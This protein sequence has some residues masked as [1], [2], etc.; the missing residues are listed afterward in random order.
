[1]KGYKKELTIIFLVIFIDLLG[2]GIII[3]IIPYYLEEFVTQPDQI[4]KVIAS[5]ITVYSLM[6]FIFS[7]I[8]GR[9]SD[10]IGR[11]PIL[12][13]SLAGSAITHVIFALG[14]NL[15]VLFVARI[16]TGIF[17][18]TVP[19]AMAYIS[20][21]TPPEDRA[22]GMGIVGA[23]FGLGFILGPALGGIVSGFAGHRVPL[24][25]AAGF[26]MTA[27]TFAYLKLKET[28]DTK[29]PVV[30]D[31]QR[32]NLKNLYRALHHP[33]LGILFLIFFIVS[34]SF[35]NFETIFALYLE[36][37]FGYKAHHAGY[38]FAMIGVISATTQGLFI[39]RLAKR[40][41]EK[42]LITTATLILG[43]AFIL[44]PFVHVLAFFLI[45]VAAIA[46]SFG[47]HN[48]SVTAL[49]SKNA[50]RT[51]QGGILGINQSFSSLGRVIGPLWAGYFF[52][53]FGPEIP[54]VS[55]GLFILL[56]M[57]LSFRLYGKSLK[58]SHQSIE[59]QR[60]EVLPANH[61][62]LD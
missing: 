11:R 32:F 9:L 20:D 49:I 8:W 3:P 22:K 6:Q 19:T 31:Y 47:M 16:L 13:M 34:T 41:G 52:D 45:I 62:K 27:F 35:A 56:A 36:R 18:A 59:Q 37:A 4:G 21:I 10:R 38:F 61:Q 5:M 29:N 55:A 43:V 12:L 1:M 42:R 15:T 57:A 46:F 58:E 48:P 60:A 53:K 44:F 54:F 24:L 23:A 30:R 40:F 25:M 33:N 26:S 17:A 50:A 28:V 39:G 7:P 14:G 51:E 2:F